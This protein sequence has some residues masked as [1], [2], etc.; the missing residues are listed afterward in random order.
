MVCRS[1]GDFLVFASLKAAIGGKDLG[2]REC[3]VSP[4]TW[5]RAPEAFESRSTISRDGYLGLLHFCISKKDPS[6]ISR[7]LK[8]G[9]PRG[10]Q[11]GRALRKM[12]F[13]EEFDYVNILPFLGH[14]LLVYFFLKGWPHFLLRIIP[15]L[16]LF[17]VG[18]SAKE[19]F[20]GHLAL[21]LIWLEARVFGWERLPLFSRIALKSLVESNP[22]NAFFAAAWARSTGGNFKKAQ[23]L[24][25]ATKEDDI[26][27]G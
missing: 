11:Q 26:T 22:R 10:F 21:V 12:G 9:F 15:K 25:E 13:W 27:W 1:S 16:P 2:V 14:L 18:K 17:L 3:E 19:G 6:I 24:L 20:R 4:G 8:A 7:I 23:R 5:V